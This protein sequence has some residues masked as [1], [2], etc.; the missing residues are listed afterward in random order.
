TTN[1]SQNSEPNSS[2]TPAIYQAIRH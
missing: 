1:R 2:V